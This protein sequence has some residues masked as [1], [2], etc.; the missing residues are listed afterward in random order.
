[1]DESPA[2][3]LERFSNQE[4]LSHV[5]AAIQNILVGG[6]SYKLGN[7]SLTRADLGILRKMRGELLAQENTGDGCLLPGTVAAFFEGRRCT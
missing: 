3:N 6:Q 1:M 5:D 2:I 4:L 7:R